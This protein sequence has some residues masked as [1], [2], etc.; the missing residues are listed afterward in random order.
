MPSVPSVPTPVA[1]FGGYS[2]RAFTERPD[3]NGLLTCVAQGNPG[4]LALSWVFPGSEDVPIGTLVPE[5]AIPAEAPRRIHEGAVTLELGEGPARALLSRASPAVRAHVPGRRLWVRTGAARAL[6]AVNG[7]PEARPR[8]SAPWTPSEPW[9]VLLDH[10]REEDFA[11]LVTLTARIHSIQWAGDGLAIDLEGPGSAHLMPLEGIRRRSPGEPPIEHLVAC[12]RSWVRPLLAFPI[13]LAERTE[14]TGDRARVH[15]HFRYELLRDSYGNEPEPLAPLPPTLALAAAAGYPVELPPGLVTGSAQRNLPTF[16]GPY[17]YVPGAQLSYSI[18]LAEGARG[19]PPPERSRDAWAEPIRAALRREAASV[20]AIDQRYAD[21]NLRNV[22]F[23][24]DALPELDAAEQAQAREFAAAALDHA[25]G[26]LFSPE[27]VFTGQRWW[28]LGKT[29]RAYF[30]D[31]A[32][33]WAKDQERFDSEFYNGQALSALLSAT[34]IDPALLGRHMDAARRLYAHDQIFWDWAT[35]SVWTHATGVSANID[36]VQFAMEGMVA[37]GILAREAGDRALEE[38]ALGRSAKQQA[39]LF[40]FWQLPAWVKEHDHA[41][42][43]VS[44]RRI[45]AAEVE[46]LGP[47]DALVEEHGACTL[48]FRSFWQC[49]NF[50]FYNNRPL[51]AFYRRHGLLP[52]IREI[53]Y[54]VMPRLHPG[55]ANGN[56]VDPH[57]ENG[58][59]R[60]GTS[61]TAAHLAARAMLFG[62]DPLPLF[63]IYEATRGTPAEGVW[64]TMHAPQVAGPLMLALLEGKPGEAPPIDVA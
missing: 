37:M 19:L 30:A 39:A 57:G 32:P 26:S 50:I 2:G 49:T 9:I 44:K 31:D 63:R 47:V 41:V 22:H 38:D 52:R 46:T 55:W 54:D 58:Q 61:W 25:F 1:T 24:G 64:Y 35:G 7:R 29:W 20:K 56:E 11:A 40:A 28:T 12:A 60:Y 6:S 62:D 51:L 33:P 14:I 45:P 42:G 15:L 27:E 53:L 34:R 10:R 13:G 23:L 36:G 59:E 16:F 5:G 43:H 18:P 8:G 17:Q 3:R 21:T 48:E 4:T